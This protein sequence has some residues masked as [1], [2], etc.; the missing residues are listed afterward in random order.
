MIAGHL[1]IPDGTVISGTTA[2]LEPIREAGI[3]T[4]AFPLMPHRDW[5]YVASIVRRLRTLSDRV[6]ALER[7]NNKEGD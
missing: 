6:R 1:D 4:S 7:Q 5:K 3:Y 2:V